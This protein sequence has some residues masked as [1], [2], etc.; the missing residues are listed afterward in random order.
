M[1]TRSDAVRLIEAHLPGAVVDNLE[2]GQGLLVAEITVGTKKFLIARKLGNI[3]NLPEQLP[4]MLAHIV[5][6]MF[7]EGML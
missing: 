4:A 1:M 3:T 6:H 5:D 7:Q 2:L